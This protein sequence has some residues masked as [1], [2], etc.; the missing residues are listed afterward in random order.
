MGKTELRVSG[1][2]FIRMSCCDKHLG[3]R[4]WLSCRVCL[5]E[6]PRRSASTPGSLPGSPADRRPQ[7]WEGPARPGCGSLRRAGTERQTQ[8]RRPGARAGSRTDALPAS[9]GGA[10]TRRWRPK[11]PYGAP[12]RTEL[13]RTTLHPLPPTIPGGPPLLDHPA[14]TRG[15]ECDLAFDFPSPRKPTSAQGSGAY[16]APAG[17][18]LCGLLFCLK[19]SALPSGWN[20]L[21]GTL[22]DVRT[23]A[24]T[25]ARLKRDSI[26]CCLW[27][28]HP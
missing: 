5:P 22:L 2:C 25:H 15:F 18:L 6:A 7:P 4:C 17:A 13:G 11:Q 3:Y 9:R 16:S 26:F 14:S 19:G 24:T 12:L 28:W 1:H 8:P 27:P 21:H 23:P 20:W 10:P